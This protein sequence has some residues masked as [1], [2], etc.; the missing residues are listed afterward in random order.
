MCVFVVH[1]MH[2][3]FDDDHQSRL[4]LVTACLYIVVSARIRESNEFCARYI[5]KYSSQIWVDAFVNVC[6]LN[7]NLF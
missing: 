5:A 3:Y 6:F 2:Y 1:I 7:A 4:L